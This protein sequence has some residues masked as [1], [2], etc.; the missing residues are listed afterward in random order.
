MRL[1]L[2]YILFAFLAVANIGIIQA[3]NSI[4]YSA[5]VEYDKWP[6]NVDPTNPY[7]D[8]KIYAYP[9][10]ADARA[11]LNDLKKGI[12]PKLKK[13]APINITGDFT[14]RVLDDKNSVVLIYAYGYEEQIIKRAEF[15]RKTNIVLK[16]NVGKLNEDNTLDEV[17]IVKNRIRK[18]LNAEFDGTEH[19]GSPMTRIA[20]FIIPY[21]LTSN[22]RIVA[23][24]VFYDRIDIANSELDTVFAYR[25]VVYNDNSEYK[26]SQARRMDFHPE[27]Y[28]S[29][30]YCYSMNNVYID[31]DSV[32][33]EEAHKKVYRED[34]SRIDIYTRKDTIYVHLIDTV[35]GC[36]P[37]PA[38][39]YPLAAIVNVVDYNTVLYTETQRDE[40]ERSA[41]LK[42]LDFEFAEFKPDS[43]AFY[44]E[45]KVVNVTHPGEMRLN[46]EVG[47]WHLSLEDSVNY[48]LMK[49]L[50]ES[51]QEIE[52]DSE[53]RTLDYVCIYGMA[54][55]DGNR[56]Q[57][58][59]LARKRAGELK[60][61]I[62]TK[63]HITDGKPVVASWEQV[64][65]SLERDGYTTVANEIREFVVTNKR[66]ISS[67]PSY[68][69]E[70]METY[71]NKFR[72]VHYKYEE[73]RR[74]KKT[75]DLILKDYKKDPWSVYYSGY[76]ILLNH[77][78]DKKQLREVARNALKVTRAAE[79]RNNP[80][81]HYGYWPYAA[82]ILAHACVATDT[83]DYTILDPFLD[84]ELYK[85]TTDN[86]NM[87][88]PAF[89]CYKNES[90]KIDHYLN[91]PEN[92]ANQLIMTLKGHSSTRIGK[93]EH[94][95]IIASAGGEA[96]Y[97]TLIAFSR[98]MR[99]EYEKDSVAWRMVAS[100]SPTNSVV[101]NL[102]MHR[103]TKDTTYL[104]AA[105]EDT[106][107]LPDNAVSNYLK[108][109]L[110][111]RKK[112]F[113]S[114][115]MNLA[116]SFCKDIKMIALANNDKDLKSEDE[117][118]IVDA[119]GYW[120][121]MMPDS[122]KKQNRKEKVVFEMP[123]AKVAAAVADSLS[124]DSLSL[125]E[126]A[127]ALPTDSVAPVKRVV[128]EEMS[129]EEYRKHPFVMF[130]EA[131]EKLIDKKQNNDAVAIDNLYKAF[132]CDI[133]YINVFNVLLVRDKNVNKDKELQKRLREIRDRY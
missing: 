42:F 32:Y 133:E 123:Q 86:D 59:D 77:L 16:K 29:L 14:V 2:F 113:D 44:E 10:E 64:A 41:P 117:H 39:P 125:S 67:I 48:K 54:S 88:L 31:Y 13:S 19:P 130:N 26:I 51:L 68:N 47:K 121:K 57:N 102:A 90:H 76:W 49:E 69:K 58:L 95:E 99:G 84:L 114:S 111:L 25:S 62:R 109:I 87:K 3:Q 45:P 21:R 1:R 124:A 55:P 110:C 116:I 91:A 98:C 35:S 43:M 115:K 81:K 7:K 37:N 38:H 63:T 112:A 72:S 92:A 66:G 24:P 30:Q 15:D 53:N 132:D 122:I 104:A 93:I 97:D 105:A 107:H 128:Y 56:Q 73:T 28:D 27:K 50:T 75:P 12:E 89:E 23:Q 80:D 4:D 71:L 82:S 79:N 61:K 103:A 18:G 17:G 6:E 126:M 22:M 9:G 85:D 78:T 52:N 74:E 127:A 83:I 131:Y 40:G 96:K 94:L 119:I 60:S 34:K 106:L 5:S 11:A 70:L 108:S 101:M 100:T 120:R 36:D 33:D 118:M 8:V 65:D 129:D 46:F 20:N